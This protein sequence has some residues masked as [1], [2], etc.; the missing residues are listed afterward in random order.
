MNLIGS[1]PPWGCRF[2]LFTEFLSCKRHCALM[3]Q[4]K[5]T[6]EYKTQ[7]VAPRSSH[8]SEI[9][10]GVQW[11]LGRLTDQGGLFW[12]DKASQRVELELNFEKQAVSRR[13][14]GRA[15][16]RQGGLPLSCTVLRCAIYALPQGH[17]GEQDRLVS[18]VLEL[19]SAE[20]QTMHQRT[21]W[22]QSP[23]PFGGLDGD[24][25][26]FPTNSCDSG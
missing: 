16:C 19:R 23:A 15:H 6:G 5:K 26:V 3:L 8:S 14:D 17:I 1:F 22:A 18:A 20:M 7:S 2:P 24:D 12:A 21:Q 4:K 10:H 25:R 11:V 13:R 9:N